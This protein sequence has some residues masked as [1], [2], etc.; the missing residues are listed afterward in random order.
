MILS[1]G[2]PIILSKITFWILLSL[3]SLKNYLGSVSRC[4]LWKNYCFPGSAVYPDDLRKVGEW[5]DGRQPSECQG[6]F[7]WPA[8]DV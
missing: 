6:R 4:A 5:C 3:I 7:G 8:V 1:P 2:V